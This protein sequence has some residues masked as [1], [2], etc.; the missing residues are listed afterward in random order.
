MT[1]IFDRT[2]TPMIRRELDFSVS[3]LSERTTVWPVSGDHI[4]VVKAG[5]EHP[6]SLWPEVPRA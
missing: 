3:V 6:V 1:D 2:P 5:G 4:T